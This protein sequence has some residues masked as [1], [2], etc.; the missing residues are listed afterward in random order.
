MSDLD[1][2]NSI[3]ALPENLKEEV[4][5]FVEFLKQK[6]EK[7][8]VKKE[9]VYGYAKGAFIIPPDFDEPLDVFK[10]YM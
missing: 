8:T 2:Y 5:D 6:A 7:K 1:L 9:R 4:S 10:D 3:I